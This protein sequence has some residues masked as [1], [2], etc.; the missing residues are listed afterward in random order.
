M[1]IV[2]SIK[3]FIGGE[4]LLEVDLIDKIIQYFLNQCFLKKP[5]LATRF[6][7]SICSNGTL[8]FDEKVQNFIDKYKTFLSFSIT[9]DGN[10]ELHDS[11]RVFKNSKKPSYDIVLK[12]VKEHMKKYG[13]TST[14]M[15]FSKE[16][17]TYIYDGIINLLNMGFT[18]I[19]CNCAFE[20]EWNIEDSK[21]IYNQ[22]KQVAD[23]IIENDLEEK[24]YISYFNEDIGAPK[25]WLNPDENKNWCGGNG[26][27]L[28][29]DYQGNW[30]PCL[31]YMPSSIGDKQPSLTCGNIFDGIDH[32]VLQEMQKVTWKSQSTD[33]CINCPIAT[34]CAWCSAYNYELFGTINKRSTNICLTHKARSLVNSYFYNRCFIKHNIE[35]RI[36][37]NLAKEEALKIINKQEYEKLISLTK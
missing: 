25:D 37:I 29:M 2:S 24:I 4:P 9:I 14:K 32:S 6:R 28:A 11:C 12:S 16:N 13:L 23:Y 22:F 17:I 7:I 26:E 33:E 30:Y 10:K 8:Y 20:P 27:M 18:H 5:K 34:G 15:T 3:D 19:N 21:I 36:P 35:K 31:R 1:G